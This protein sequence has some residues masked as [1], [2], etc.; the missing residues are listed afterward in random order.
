MSFVSLHTALSGIRAAR[1][2]MDTA[3]H[4]VANANTPGYTRQ[5]V[6]LTTSYP[7]L[8]AH[9]PIGTGVS[10]ADISR[11]RDSFLDARVRGDLANSGSLDV[12]AELLGR[13]ELVLGEPENGLTGELTEVWAA[14]EDLALRPE[15]RASRRQVLSALEALS[16]RV[17][18]V[19]GGLQTL[20]RDTT[21]SLGLALKE[22]NGLFDQVADLNARILDARGGG[23]TPND[24]LDERDAA[25]DRLSRRIGATITAEDNGTV[26]VSVSGLA[27]VSGTSAQHLSLAPDTGTI[28]HPAGVALAP[29][30]EVGGLQRFVT[31]DLPKLSGALDAFVESLVP[32]MNTQHAVGYTA[33]D[34]QVNGGDLFGFDPSAPALTLTARITEP[35]Q[36][37]AASEPG[38]PHDGRNA[39]ALAGLR[40]STTLD[41]DLRTLVT[42]HAAEVAATQRAADGQAQLAAAAA[43][44]RD[45]MHGVSLDEELVA[46]LGY[47]RALEASSRVMSA[48]DQ[49]LDVIINRTGLV[50]R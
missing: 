34:P 1:V 16:A 4:N 32:A 36:L 46:M 42:E 33:E 43:T 14:F 3:A 6:E 49:A 15:D 21:T 8:S 39:A 38:G 40:T 5:R 48:V 2:G 35:D 10:V 45:G 25:V 19:A 27:V 12:R 37:A 23:A 28:T 29:A 11:V 18:S 17:R 24:L 41:A 20:G 50:G 7:Y 47:Q 9:G 44:A 22:V 13:A 31:V 26:R 30:G